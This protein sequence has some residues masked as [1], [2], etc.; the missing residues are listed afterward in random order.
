MGEGWGGRGTGEQWRRS[1]AV[2]PTYVQYVMHKLQL[3]SL[4]FKAF[5]VFIVRN[6]IIAHVRSYCYDCELFVCVCVDHYLGSHVSH[7]LWYVS[8]GE[9]LGAKVLAL[10]DRWVVTEL[11]TFHCY[12][13]HFSLVFTWMWNWNSNCMTNQTC[14]TSYINSCAIMC[15]A[16]LIGQSDFFHLHGTPHLKHTVMHAYMY[17]RIWVG[18]GSSVWQWLSLIHMYY[19]LGGFILRVPGLTWPASFHC[20][21]FLHNKPIIQEQK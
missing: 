7:W 17:I 10:L 15:T 14:Y 4:L 9:S 5:L 12:R 3:L 16:Y 2:V 19:N 1:I 6:L 21:Y 20:F 18:S 8:L 13:T 11:L